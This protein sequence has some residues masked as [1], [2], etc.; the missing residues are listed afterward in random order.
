[1]RSLIGL[2]NVII[3]S[4]ILLTIGSVSTQQAFAGGAAFNCLAINNGN[5]N[6]T[7]NWDDCNGGIPDSSKDAQIADSF[8]IRITG[9]QQIGFFN[10]INGGTLF[11][12]CDASLLVV[13]G[14][15]VVENANITNH[16]NFTASPS[17]FNLFATFFNSGDQSGLDIREGGSIEE[18][19]TI[20]SQPIGGTVGSMGTVSLLVAG[21]QANMGLWSLALVGMVAAGAVITY[22]LKSKKTEQ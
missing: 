14:G 11:I 3:F 19:S 4:V 10:I 5:W 20:C 13:R 16:G 8:D 12:D 7:S 15:Q 17:D 21:A 18:I 6:I 2:K 22:K 1:M 9:D